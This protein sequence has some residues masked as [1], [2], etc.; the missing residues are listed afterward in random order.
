MRERPDASDSS[1]H[2]SEARAQS[3]GHLRGHCFQH[4]RRGMDGEVTR[5]IVAVC[6]R[7]V[8]AM[9]ASR[10]RSFAL[11]IAV[12]RTDLHGKSNLEERVR[13]A[14]GAA[15]QT[16]LV[17]R[18]D[19]VATR[20]TPVQEPTLRAAG[21]GLASAHRL[22]HDLE[23]RLDICSPAIVLGE[24]ARK[25]HHGIISSDLF[26]FCYRFGAVES[27]L[28]GPEPSHAPELAVNTCAER[29]V[30]DTVDGRHARLSD[31]GIDLVRAHV[32]VKN[33]GNGL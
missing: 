25:H 13:A 30:V 11:G 9:P 12:S 31:F 28:L 32:A 8:S 20:G 6:V 24:F 16:P 22:L 21:F 18:E 23:G 1:E 17:E 5:R 10:E 7:R 33:L 27:L 15:A 19:R 3:L 29:A 2:T 26:H 14:L 4:E